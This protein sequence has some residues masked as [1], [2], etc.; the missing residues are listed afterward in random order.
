MISVI[1]FEG[2]SRLASARATEIG[3]VSL[4]KNLNVVEEFESLVNP[5]V[6]PDRNA[7]KV[8]KLGKNDLIDAPSF[9][10]LWPNL[11][12]ILSNTLLIAHNKQY[13][14]N[15]LR[16]EFAD[17]GIRQ[18]PPFICTLEWSRKILGSK[19]PNH[20]LGTICEYLRI[21]LNN[22]HEAISDARATAE[23]LR[24]LSAKSAD[25]EM[26]IRRQTKNLV[27]FSAPSRKP[28]ETLLR[29]RININKFDSMQFNNAMKRI[30]F[31]GFTT[32]VIT[33][34]PVQGK[35][36]LGL[37]L[38][39]IGL[40]YKETPPTKKTAFVVVSNNESGISKIRKAQELNVPL[41]SESDTAK[42][43][44]QLK[45]GRA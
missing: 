19:I 16:N 5:P 30:N 13:E 33:G 8:S 2:T 42:L 24:I 4:D 14:I 9:F 38:K 25:L 41:L 35:D 7:L 26:E 1:D 36:G 17:L 45:R 11:Q 20:T 10:H 15:V 22:P 12:P 28:A 44:S 37:E 40:D 43:I 23:V 21:D 29:N 31:L 34:V 27:T 3:I 18:I 39:K 32:V 6:E